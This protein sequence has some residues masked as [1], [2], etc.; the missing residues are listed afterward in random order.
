MKDGKKTE[1][2]EQMEELYKEHGEEEYKFTVLNIL[3]EEIVVETDY[4]TIDEVLHKIKLDMITLTRNDL[5]DNQIVI[6]I[7]PR[8][9]GV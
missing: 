7:K 8:I 1:R 9:I 3:G 2:E 5:I 6:R 4:S